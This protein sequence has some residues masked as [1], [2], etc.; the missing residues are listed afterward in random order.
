[1]TVGLWLGG[2]LPARDVPPHVVTQVVAAI[3]AA[4]V[5]LF[6]ANGSPDYDLDTNGL[7]ATASASPPQVATPWAPPW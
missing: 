1:V 3:V 6:V 7:A 2:R 5:L 4:A